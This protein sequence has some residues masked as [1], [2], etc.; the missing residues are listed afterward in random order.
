MFLL[1]FIKEIVFL[2]MKSVVSISQV[3]NLWYSSENF[4]ELHKGKLNFEVVDV[5]Q[6]LDRLILGVIL[7][8]NNSFWLG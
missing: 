8:A 1:T 5:K 3:C 4:K 6:E 2:D 7:W